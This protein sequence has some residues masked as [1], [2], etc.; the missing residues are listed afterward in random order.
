MP[1]YPSKIIFFVA[2]SA[3]NFIKSLC[4]SQTDGRGVRYANTRGQVDANLNFNDDIVYLDNNNITTTES[5]RDADD[6]EPITRFIP[7]TVDEFA[8][9][10]W[11]YI[12]VPPE[13]YRS[14]AAALLRKKGMQTV[15]QIRNSGGLEYTLQG[16]EN[17]TMDD[18]IL[19]VQAS[20]NRDYDYFLNWHSGTVT[21][22]DFIDMLN[23]SSCK[24]IVEDI[25]GHALTDETLFNVQHE[26]W[27]FLNK[28]FIDMLKQDLPNDPRLQ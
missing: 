12:C 1:T 22:I 17:P 18:V 5:I 27:I 16:L 8:G 21:K 25:L 20:Y 19:A 24:Q 13:C 10:R 23:L 28:W 14:V 26:S 2:G 4:I 3:G 6:I 11:F 15:D 7:W 9:T